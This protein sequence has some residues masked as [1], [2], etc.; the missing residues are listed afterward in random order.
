MSE[1]AELYR[2]K[3]RKLL[4]KVPDA[5]E[6]RKRQLL[7]KL[8]TRL[9]ETPEGKAALEADDYSSSWY[10]KAWETLKGTAK[11]VPGVLSDY[12]EAAST[13]AEM[14]GPVAERVGVN[15]LQGIHGLGENVAEAG[16]NILERWQQ[17]IQGA[18]SVSPEAVATMIPGPHQPALQAARA[19]LPG[20]MVKSQ[21]ET[22]ADI[23]R[24]G[25]AGL[26]VAWAPVSEVYHAV[27]RVAHGVNPYRLKRDVE[28]ARQL[29]KQ[30]LT[31]AEQQYWKIKAEQGEQA[32]DAFAAV[33]A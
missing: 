6:Q 1:Y 21:G 18:P 19:L 32:A 16:R 7:Y 29:Q 26:E 23:G 4:A 17:A 25:M 30:K 31:E 5:D 15:L 24:L 13:A 3:A 10:G 9:R 20:S 28:F 11:E 33:W 14:A 8:D 22:L 27:S 2:D 12:G